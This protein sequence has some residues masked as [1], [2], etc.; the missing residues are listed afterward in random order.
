MITDREIQERITQVI[1]TDATATASLGN[2]I[3]DTIPD[4][5]QYPVVSVGEI[6]SNY[7]GTLDGEGREGVLTVRIVGQSDDLLQ[8]KDIR[9]NLSRVLG[10]IGRKIG[11]H[12]VVVW[13]KGSD[14]SSRDP[15]NKTAVATVDFIF[16]I[17]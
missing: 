2:R 8:V 6:T 9:D 1:K 15:D 7:V 14:D 16:T 13:L 5:P 11:E 17:F 3:Y 10:D 12:K 4:S